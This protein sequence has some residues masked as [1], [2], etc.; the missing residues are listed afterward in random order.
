MAH[1]KKHIYCLC[2]LLYL[3]LMLVGCSFSTRIQYE[4]NDGYLSK[5]FFKSIKKNQTNRD[6]V[7]NTLGKPV[8]RLRTSDG[9]EIYT[10]AFTKSIYRYKK[11]IFFLRSNSVERDERY[12]HVVFNDMKVKKYWWD[13]LAYVNAKDTIISRWPNSEAG[14]DY[15]LRII[16]NAEPDKTNFVLTRKASKST[17]EPKPITPDVTP[18]EKIQII[19]TDLVAPK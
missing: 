18:T 1:I 7:I 3:L 11:I 14:T 9:D 17:P 6:V 4:D 2:C 16:K 8:E 12:F 13:K 19:P 5:S 15:S 10:Y